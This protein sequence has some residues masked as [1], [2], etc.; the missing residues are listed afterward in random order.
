MAMATGLPKMAGDQLAA[1]VK[2]NGRGWE[3]AP[4]SMRETQVTESTEDLPLIS[5]KSELFWQIYRSRTEIAR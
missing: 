1:C 2:V 5:A 4:C 3:L